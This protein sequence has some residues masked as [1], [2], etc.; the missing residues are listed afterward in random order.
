MAY[1]GG[2][3]LAN[4]NKKQSKDLYQKLTRT[5]EE[6]EEDKERE[7]DAERERGDKQTLLS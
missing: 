6:I 4:E 3:L 5:R 2:F 7:R 1:L